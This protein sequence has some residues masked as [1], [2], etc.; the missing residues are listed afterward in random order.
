MGGTEQHNSQIHPK[1]EHFE[2]LRL[3]E[4]QHDNST[5][6]RQRDT[7][8]NRT[9]HLGQSVRRSFQSAVF[10]RHRETVHQV[11]TELDADAHR[12]YQIY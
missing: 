2:D 6:L 11:R 1:V 3:G 8:E 7:G 4:V 12:H 9:A 5:K 10:H